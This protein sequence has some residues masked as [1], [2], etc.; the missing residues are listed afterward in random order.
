[1][2]GFGKNLLIALALFLVIAAIFTM[3]DSPLDEPEIIPL[4]NLAAEINEEKIQSIEVQGNDLKVIQKDGTEQTALKEAESSL[5]ESLTNFGVNTNKLNQLEIIYK[6]ESRLSYY[7]DNML[8][9]IVPFIFIGIFIYF[10][11]RGVQKGNTR[12]MSFGKTQAKQVDTKGKKRVTFKDVAGAV[13]AKEEL[14]EVVQFL[15]QPTKFTSLG[16]QIPK[17]VLL[18]GPP[19][20]GKT[21][22]ARA[23]A[24]EAKVPF[25]NISGSEFVEMFVGVGASRVRDLFDKAKKN[26]PAILFIDEIDAVG[27]HRGAGLGGSHD[28]REQTLNQILSE[29]DGFEQNANVIVL[30]ATN[31]PDILDPALLRPGRFDRRVI[32]TEPD[33]KE[34]EAILK[35]YTRNKPL[36]SNVKIKILAQ[37]T[38]GF[39]GADLKNLM[40]EAAILSGK[41]NKKKI[42]MDEC[43]ESIEKVML[44]PERRSRMLSKK[45]KE[46]AAYHEAGHALVSHVLPHAD[47]VHKVSIISRGQAAGYT[48]KLPEEE[49]SFHSKSEFLDDL[50]VLLAGHAAEKK[51]FKDITTGATSDLRQAT[52]L[53]RKLTTEFGM[54]DKLGPMT[55]GHKEELV[56][57]G[58][59]IGE[60]RDYSEEVA[61][62]I[63]QEVQRFITEAYKQ[64]NKVLDT[65][66]GKLKE[67]AKTLIEKEM[68]EKEDFNK[69]VKDI[70]K[71]DIGRKG[72]K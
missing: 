5:S 66:H 29:M 68:L 42:T 14:S 62:K 21:L 64:A 63:D 28:E 7:M 43:T 4:S 19:G 30:A 44:G 48:L 33:I 17:G 31:R 70:K 32:I 45:E 54:S 53:A 55:F 36:D 26:A 72:I 51:I 60:Q 1:M 24:G 35:I 8:I 15:K 59:E 46:I 67:I 40:N 39:T 23:V 3:Y 56:F 65:Y 41:R 11:T 47:P 16:A 9:F 61:Y 52:S 25:F 2:K 27:R 34:R 69:L 22:L 20:V 58:K 71:G 50:S 6:E 18:L 37:R 12:A 57:L 10:L 49:K 13:E 38:P